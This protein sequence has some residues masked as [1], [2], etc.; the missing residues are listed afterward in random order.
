M[1]A[2]I[3]LFTRDLRLRD[4]PVLT[5]AAREATE[6]V[7]LFVLDE[8]IVR[9]TRHA[10]NRLRFLLAALSELDDE[11]RARGGRLVLRRGRTVDVVAQVAAEVGASA[12][13]V[14][15]DV[16][17][18]SQGRENA[19]WER[20]SPTGCRVRTHA[21]SITAVDPAEVKPD[22]G[23]GHYAIFTP[24][25]RRWIE[26]PMRRPLP[27]PDRLVVPA[28]ASDPIPELGDLCADPASP[29]LSVGGEVTGRKLLAHW[30]SGPVYYYA[31]RKDA[32]AFEGTSRLSPYLHFGCLSPAEVVHRT[33]AATSGGH[34]FVRQVAWRDFHHQ[35]LA[36]RPEV[37]TRDYRSESRSWVHEPDGLAAWQAGRT[38]YPVV[39]AAM[40]QL[41]A[42]GWMPGRARLIAASFLSKTLKV[43]WRLGA[44][45]FE[46]WLV[47][48]DLA[49]NRMNWQWVAGT[50]T[51]TRSSRVLNPL[52]QADRYDPDGVYARRWL[53]ELAHLPGA[54]VH[55]PWRAGVPASTY[56][57]PIVEFR[58]M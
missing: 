26:T 11:L 30:L 4:N 25:F 33:D 19:L 32:L 28:I 43:D 40:R 17:R 31:E 18:Y 1:P 23:R 55:R 56:P 7:P 57:P 3:A 37:A 9:R 21:A 13:H 6:V 12:V 44:E 47:D 49:N 27:A 39:D 29:G 14:A 50:G 46:R 53:P 2:S 5:A 15:E 22:T 38:G 42:Q 51:D 58:G 52:R 24:Y 8:E 16:S 34:A 45:H 41:L 10:P 20:L 35:V 36:D 54:D 48:A